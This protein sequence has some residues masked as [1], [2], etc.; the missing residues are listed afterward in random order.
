MFKI[1]RTIKELDFKQVYD[2]YEQTIS[3]TG[4]GR[5]P[6]EHENVQILLAQQD[7]YA[8]LRSFLASENTFCALWVEDGVYCS[9]LQLEQYLGG[10]L[11]TSLETALKARGKGYAKELVR[12]SVQHLEEQ[13]N[14]RIYSHIDK[15]NYASVAVH[16]CCGF[17]KYLDYGVYLDG[18][19]FR[20]SDTYLY[21]S[22]KPSVP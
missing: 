4:K 10:Y 6:A 11:I 22:D 12:H 14:V 21:E 2:V 5:Y 7:L 18:S 19:V 8:A 3:G 13:G 15:N 20:S 16:R 17:R 1:V 9:V